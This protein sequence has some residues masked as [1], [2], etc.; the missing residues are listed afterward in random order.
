MR[1]NTIVVGSLGRAGSTVLYQSI[2]QTVKYK[3]TDFQDNLSDSDYEKGYVYKTHD[4][5][6]TNSP[7]HIKFIW[8]FADPY[9]IVLSVLNQEEK[10]GI[11]WVKNHFNNLKGEFDKYDNIL[12]YDAMR[13]EEHFDKW[14]QDH[15]FEL[16]T[17]KY[18]S[19]WKK[20]REMSR[21]IGSYIDLP[22]FN[23]REDRFSKL[24]EDKKEQ[25]KDTY[26]NLHDKVEKAED[27][28]VW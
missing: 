27:F 11:D 17:I 26:G 3:L 2:G 16:L 18:R 1:D 20:Q 25:L 15:N 24:D 7:D 12:N 21:F 9:E 13:L 22:V 14:Y 23:D 8:T 10:K 4:F 5:P 19:I 28:K 6:P